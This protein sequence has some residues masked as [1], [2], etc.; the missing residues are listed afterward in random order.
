MHKISDHCEESDTT[1]T[2][3]EECQ[4]FNLR[5]VD[6]KPIE[7]DFIIGNKK[8]TMELDTG[9]G[10]CLISEKLYTKLFSNY[11]LLDSQLKMCLYNGHKI[12]PIGFF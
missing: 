1:D 4:N 11:K 10:T 6:K 3:C 5:Y 9:S 2:M 7:L 12:S 8:I